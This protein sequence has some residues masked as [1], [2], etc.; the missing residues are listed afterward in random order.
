[1]ELFSE[2]I[3]ESNSKSKKKLL[4]LGIIRRRKNMIR[5]EQPSI[6]LNDFRGN[7]RY[8]MWRTWDAR[9]ENTTRDRII[10]EIR[11][12]ALSVPN[13]G[14]AIN[15]V[16]AGHGYPGYLQVGEGFQ[17]QHLQMFASWRGL[18]AT[19]WLM[20]CLVGRNVN[21]PVQSDSGSYSGDGK[22]FC[23]RLAHITE[24][25]VIASTETQIANMET[26]PYG[27]ISE[28]EGRVS[29]FQAGTG[30]IIAWRRNSS[31]WHDGQRWHGAGETR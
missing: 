14:R 13:G 20:G 24:A 22:G 25:N 7:A 10:T 6:A 8:H 28:M 19:I 9:S 31:A 23:S 29:L 16:I 17:E 11:N 4:N 3:G 27:Y 26:Y 2:K 21:M 30:Q 12:L 15:L 18:F 5:L 1:L